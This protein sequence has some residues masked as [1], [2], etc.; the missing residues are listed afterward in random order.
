MVCSAEEKDFEFWFPVDLVKAEGD[1]VRSDRETQWRVG[2]IASDE[3]AEDL[4]GETVF[5]KGLDTSYLM[6]RGVFNWDHGKEPGDIIG[7]IDKATRQDADTKLWV[8]GFLYQD[9][10]KAQ[11][12]YNL[13]KS[14]KTSGSKRQLGMSLE[15][16]VKERDGANGKL[17]KKAWIKAVAL[18]YNPVNKGTFADFIKSLGK[19]EWSPCTGECEKCAGCA[20]AEPP[21]EKA[22]GI[23]PGETGKCPLCGG[24]HK[25]GECPKTEKVETKPQGEDKLLAKTDGGGDAGAGLEAG[26]DAPATSGGVSGS[27]LRRQSLEQDKK[28]TTY[29]KKD[30]PNKKKKRINKSDFISIIKHKGY[31]DQTANELWDLF[32]KGELR[33]INLN[34]SEMTRSQAID[35]LHDK[36]YSRRIS[37]QLADLAILQKNAGTVFEMALEKALEKSRTI[38]AKDV[39]PRKKRQL[40]VPEQHQLKIARD[41]IKNPMKGKFLGGPSL[42]EAQE[43]VARLTKA[44][45]PKASPAQAE[46]VH[47]VMHEFKH[48]ELHSGVGKKGKKGPKVTERDQAVAIALSEAGL[49]KD[50]E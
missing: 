42:E 13:I 15:G 45:T 38:G 27:A 20:C 46:K 49:S 24:E 9:V 35:Y 18:T 43:I 14:L 11:D 8:E 37:A 12:T 16:K 47:T 41:T 3:Q 33:G 4:Q 30:F 26:Y 10:K 1:S 50:K 5:I 25:D 40:S 22:L 23:K 36:G 48:G 19:F 29:T 17:I 7:E 6:E 21:V 31:K 2:G 39:Q 34:K 44:R 28:V 32:S